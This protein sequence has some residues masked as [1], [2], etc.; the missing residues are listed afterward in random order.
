MTAGLGNVQL[1]LGLNTTPATAALQQYYQKLTQGAKKAAGSQKPVETSL[2]KLVEAAKKLGLTFDKTT[3]SFRNAKGAT[4][5]IKE[6]KKRVDELN[7][8]LAKT[9][10]VAQQAL[11]GIGQGF[12]QVLQGI[13]QGI[14]LAIGQQLLAPLTNF[15]GVIGGA[16]KNSVGTFVELD[17]SLRQTAS[18]S[19]ATAAE[20][21]ELQQAV[22][23]LAK[24]TKF[25]TGELAEASVALARAG[26]S[27]S[28]VQEALPGIAQG[29]AAA[30]S[31]MAEMS[32]VVIAALGAFQKS[33]E[34]T[35][36]V[37][38]IRTQ[39]ANNSNTTVQ[40]LG[41]GLK[42]VGPIAK[43]LGL[44]FEDVAAA[45]GLLANSGIKASQMGT[46]LRSGLNRLAGAANGSNS[47]FTKLSRGTGRMATVL[48]KLGI[49]LKDT[50][51]NLKS[52][53][54]LLKSL[55][56]G[57][58][59]LN[60]T[61]KN[62]AA[63]ILFGDEAGS[64]WQALLNQNIDEIERF[65]KLTNNASGVAAE[66]AQ[67]NLTGI[68]GS[69]TFLSSAFD[70]ASAKVGEFL[71][72]ILK[73]LIDGITLLLNAF[74][75]LPGPIQNVVLAFGALTV[76][77]GVATAA[78]VLFQAAAGAGMF[79]GLSVAIT[80]TG[81]MFAGLA[82][83][84]KG[85][86]I[87]ALASAKAGFIAF[88]AAMTANIA[89]GPIF[90]AVWAKIV[91][92]LAA[93]KAGT[94]GL[95][96]SL[97]GLTAASIASW[98]ASVAA[99][100]K[101]M[102]V[103]AL[104]AGAKIKA[105]LLAAAPFAAVAAAVASVA[106]VWDTYSKTVQGANEVQKATGPILDEV[107]KKLQEQ[108]IATAGANAGWE[109]SVERV[110]HLQASL[111]ILRS[112]IGLTTAEE[113]QLSQTTVALGDHYGEVVSSIDQLIGEMDQK[114]QQLAGLEKGT[115][116]YNA[117][118][119]ELN[120]MQKTASKAI[121]QSIQR[122]VA[123]KD[124]LLAGRLES[125]K[126]TEEEQT[127]PNVLNSLIKSFELSKQRLGLLAGQYG[128]AANAAGEFTSS[129]EQIEQS[130][131]EGKEAFQGNMK[132]MEESFK[133][134]KKELQAG[135]K[136][137]VDAINE[138]IRGLKEESRVFQEQKDAELRA[139]KDMKEANK[140]YN[141]D[142]R[143]ESKRTN[144]AIIQD[145]QSKKSQVTA[146]YDAEIDAMK[147]AQSAELKRYDSQIAAMER[148][149]RAQMRAFDREQRALDKLARATTKRYDNAIDGLRDLTP[150]E[151]QL[152]ALELSRLQKEAA[153]G[154]E[155]GLRARAQL[156]RFAR[157]QQIAQLEEEKERKLEQIEAEKEKKAAQARAAQEKHEAKM[158]KKREERAK[159]EEEFQQKLLELLEEKKE[160]ET[161]AQ[162]EID[163]AKQRAKEEEQQLRDNEVQD[164]RDFADLQKELEE[165]KRQDK[166]KTDEYVR[167]LEEERRQKEEE[168]LQLIADAES[169]FAQQ[170]GQLLESYNDAIGK[171]NDYI[172]RSGETTW[173]TYANNA[174]AQINRIA[175]A[176]RQAA[177]A[178]APK[179]KWTGGPVSG[180]Q[181]YT[182]NELGQEAFLSNSGQLSMINAPAFGTWRAPSSGTVLN[183]AV[184][185]K[186]GLP[187]NPVNFGKGVEIN[188]NGGNDSANAG[189]SETR[190]LMRAIAAATGGD[191]ITNNVSIQ[192]ANTTQAA[193]DIM[194][195]LTK[196]KRRRIR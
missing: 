81:A 54:E 116:Q 153:G 53:P 154:G 185:E 99:S 94:L 173:R 62:L 149:H 192:A 12:K 142:V 43:S 63:K 108:G 191:N 176:N 162:K 190:A 178:A 25:T 36:A 134:L 171:T 141:E 27:A 33:T 80:Q 155:E 167:K 39:A 68:A 164:A 23:G 125:G 113:A 74:N 101:A 104:A 130:L 184:T 47:E 119:D 93:A 89:L 41:E 66:T 60:Q 9:Q 7:R 32:D 56:G 76:A 175:E 133:N 22:I 106:V 57:F 42:Y 58:D 144:E 19:G 186:L 105:M 122:L 59:Q 137:E 52:M 195:E 85:A 2:N 48:Q 64:A 183:A 147:K 55:K 37:V 148:A 170:R 181:A 111:D 150:A 109:R 4:V 17:K 146:A 45:A 77:V 169:D 26:F 11:G 114:A 174:I 35:G 165:Q 103:S 151:K 100:F 88:N 115:A 20:F 92:G 121:Q 29:A 14:G 159:K 44:S 124:A 49:D 143:R 194:V 51:G 120:G 70:A 86:V 78:Y 166:Q 82:L 139:L 10:Q 28:E 31:G 73:P 95:V 87:G 67:K 117:V 126:F 129:Q 6:T 158:A 91:A 196:I 182:V 65:A 163:E 18:I 38:D 157:E 61:E 83:T 3:Q 145:L 127:Q 177:A 110:G 123:Q 128:E 188:P 135:I 160:A 97:K 15:Q 132:A 112:K 138:Q 21:A 96:A 193:S 24:D 107:N 161:E 75:A 152:Q 131:E 30:G 187:S 79:A 118:L 156:E 1:S 98:A 46:A 69:L 8:S 84:I 136:A 90:T 71:G 189:A 180:G 72:A 172:V 102:G 34:E 168:G 13:P 50:N 5:T 179:G 40:E 140:R 16:V